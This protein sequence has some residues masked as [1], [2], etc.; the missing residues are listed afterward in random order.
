M[1]D[2]NLAPFKIAFRSEGIFVVA[3]FSSL[4]MYDGSMDP[5]EVARIRKSALEQT[6]G[7]FEDFQALVRKV[8]TQ[9]CL[10]LGLPAPDWKTQRAPEDERTG[11]A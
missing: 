11:E 2:E 5:I 9:M 1:T 8:V 3:Y 7:L 6:E 4:R 10:D